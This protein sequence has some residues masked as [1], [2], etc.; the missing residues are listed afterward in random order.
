MIK[1]INIEDC[2]FNND[3]PITVLKQIILAKNEKN[4]FPFLY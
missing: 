4:I 2:C 1:S 3:I